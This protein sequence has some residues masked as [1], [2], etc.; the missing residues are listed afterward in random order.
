MEKRK[1]RSL[2]AI[3]S[4]PLPLTLSVDKYGQLPLVT[5]HNPVSWLYLLYRVASIYFSTPPQFLEPKLGVEVVDVG[6]DVV[7]Q[8]RNKPDMER[9]WQQGFF[10]KGTLSRSDPTWE[11]RTERRLNINGA[12]NR[13]FT[14]EDVTNVRRDDRKAFKALRSKSQEFEVMERKRKLT[15]E[16]ASEWEKVKAEMEKMKAT[17]SFKVPFGQGHEAPTRKEDL[18]LID[19]ETKMLKA[20]LETL[21]LQKIELFFLHFALNVVEVSKDSKAILLDEVFDLCMNRRMVPENKFLLDYAVY[22]H[23]RSMGWCVR[24]GIKFGCDMLLY[25]RGPPF[26][27]AEYAI[28]VIPN[29]GEEWTTWEDFMAVARVVSGVK[30]TLVL[31]Y[32]DIPAQAVFDHVMQMLDAPAKY[33]A[34]MQNYRVTEVIYKRWSPARTRD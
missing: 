26:M 9:L 1:G 18:G 14:K 5:A 6:A 17:N 32:V 10:G 16:E 27:H 12:G 15:S 13:H 34:L 25:K 11:Q 22:H 20:N 3:Y 8:V 2:N 23:F 21:Q 7:F 33:R 19:P 30:K 24:S 4:K 31:V 29:N 28:L